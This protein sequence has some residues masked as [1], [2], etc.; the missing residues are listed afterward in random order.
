M[1]GQRGVVEVLSVLRQ[2]L[3]KR[4]SRTI[5]DLGRTFRALD[6]FD[7]NKKVDRQEFA[8][9]LRE[10]GVNLSPQEY[11][12]LFDYFDKDRDG[13]VNFDEFLVGIRG[14]PNSRRQAL[15]DKAFLK[16]DR[17]GNG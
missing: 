9:G 2:Q 10:N 15:I 8:V 6:S 7:G 16:F 14:Q 12:V 4:G 3:E 5:R 11:S 1:S 13:T 17:D